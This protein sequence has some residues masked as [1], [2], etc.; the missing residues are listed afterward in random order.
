MT[1]EL[2]LMGT[3]AT[4]LG[5]LVFSDDDVGGL[6][7][8]DFWGDFLVFSTYMMAFLIISAGFNIFLAE[9]LTCFDLVFN[10]EFFAGTAE[11]FWRIL[12]ALGIL[13]DFEKF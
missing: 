1:F 13:D 6:F 2:A 10:F 9:T 4:D 7:D 12:V 11:A 3:F 5:F 8:G